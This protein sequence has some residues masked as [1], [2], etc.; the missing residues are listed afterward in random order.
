MSLL[1]AAPART[2]Q[3]RLATTALDRKSTRLNSSH[4]QISYAVFCLKKNQTM[5][6]VPIELQSPLTSRALPHESGHKHVTGEAIYVD[7]ATVGQ[8]MLEVW[9][10]CSPH[11]RAKI[12]RRDALAAKTMPG[13]AAVL[14]A[15]DIPG[16]NDVGAV[17]HDEILLADKEV[18]YH[19]QIVALVVGETQEACRAAADKVVVEYEPLSPNF[20]IQEA[21]EQNR[22]HTEENQVSRGDFSRA[23]ADSP[24][25]LEGELAIGGQDHFYLETNAAGADPREGG[26]DLVRSFT[27]TPSQ[28]RHNNAPFTANP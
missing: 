26:P 25:T 22:F 12:L 19:G 6:G 1:P 9:P 10:V 3:E 17:R 4:S 2:L 18:F 20:T 23:F 13:I 7:D 5:Q 11:A 24:I 28:G 15:E 8:E 21:I 16:L 14:L 27:Q